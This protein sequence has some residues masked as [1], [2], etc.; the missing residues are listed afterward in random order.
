MK[1]VVTTE[2]GYRKEFDTPKEAV[3]CAEKI[4]DNFALYGQKAYIHKEP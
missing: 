4:D 2:G 3:E 1:Y